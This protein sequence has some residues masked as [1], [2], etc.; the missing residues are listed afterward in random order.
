MNDRDKWALKESLKAVGI[1]AIVIVACFVYVHIMM[2][3][4]DKPWAVLAIVLGTALI[5]GGIYGF[6]ELR[7]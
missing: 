1:V 2:A 7:K 3:L 5:G 6:F 4:I